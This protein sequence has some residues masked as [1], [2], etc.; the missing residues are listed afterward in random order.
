MA[1]NPPLRIFIGYDEKEADAFSVCEHSLEKHASVP[2]EIVPLKQSELKAAKLY[3][4]QDKDVSTEFAFT[5]FLV[6]ILCNYK[7]WALFCDC[8]MLF[9]RDVKEL[10]DMADDRYAVMVVQHDYTP[11]NSV[12]MDGKKQTAHPRKNWSSLVLWNCGHPYNQNVNVSLVNGKSPA[13]LHQF[14]WL[15]K[16]DIGSLPLEWNWLEGEYD[17]PEFPPANIHYTQGGPWFEQWQN[18][19][20]A[21][22]WNQH[23]K[24]V[25]DKELGDELVEWNAASDEDE[26]KLDLDFHVGHAVYDE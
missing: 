1:V 17:K 18:V 25:Q 7:G 8:D 24:E 10:F 5:R 19:D 16:R 13:F 12:K 11:V 15:G 3:K 21:D 22:M 14:K 4:R 26:D 9:T 6:P 2:L 20:Y 23:Y